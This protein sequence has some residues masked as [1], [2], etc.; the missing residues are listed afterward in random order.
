MFNTEYMRKHWNTKNIT[1]ALKITHKIADVLG[2][3]VDNKNISR[4]I[5]STYKMYLGS[6]Q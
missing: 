2:S 6:K 1:S 4:G 5:S 3:H